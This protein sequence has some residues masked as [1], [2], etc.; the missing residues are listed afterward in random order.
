MVVKAEG[1]TRIPVAEAV[2]LTR[3][4]EMLVGGDHRSLDAYVERVGK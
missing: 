4:G 1:T 3:Y 2:T